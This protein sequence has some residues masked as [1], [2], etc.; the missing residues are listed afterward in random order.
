MTRCHRLLSTLLLML[1]FCATAAPSEVDTK[2][3]LS[4]R[5]N[6]VGRMLHA[7]KRNDAQAL[8]DA[9]AEIEALAYPVRGDRRRARK[10]NTSALALFNAGQI[11]AALDEFARA[12]DADPSDQEIAGNYGFVLYRSHR[13]ADAERLLRRTLA[14]SPMRSSAWANLAEVLGTRGDAETAAHA[15][16]VAYGL[17]RHAETTRLY[18][19]KAAAESDS[20]GLKQ[21][22]GIALPR[23]EA[24]RA[25]MQGIVDPFT[26]SAEAA[27]RT[28]TQSPAAAVPARAEA[29]PV[30]V[31]DWFE[32]LTAPLPSPE[33][34][35]L[36]VAARDGSADARTALVK[37]ANA[38]NPRAQNAVG[39]L[40]GKVSGPAAS[41]DVAN[42][43]Y[44]RSAAQ[45][46]VLAQVNLALNQQ[47]GLGTPVDYPQAVE[48]YRRAA[49]QGHPL[50]M[51]NLGFMY[52]RGLGVPADPKQALTWF[53]RAAEAGH[54]QGIYNAGVSIEEG[55]GT[56][57]DPKRAFAFYLSAA[58][59]DF[60]QAQLRVAH[61][62]KLGWGGVKDQAL[63]IVW[64]RK[65]ARFGLEQAREALKRL[66]ASDE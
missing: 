38:G 45:G 10:L 66:G 4:E 39:D 25:G 28:E 33:V 15:F 16:V 29:V 6:G 18:I 31:A 42:E 27:R 23:L 44:R 13:L 21:A 24:A 57:A 53:L 50:A 61:G 9:K 17:S 52:V 2:S 5:L 59:G 58:A 49:G 3:A 26:A 51:N 54:A 7:T 11:E 20:V 32:R 43:W 34:T 19:E 35:R 37:L 47:Y 65:A 55:L 63:A 14:L 22:V 30:A 12:F 48:G 64:Y 36:F 46:F 41:A 56:A 62:Y 1:S 40:Y 8:W 60:P